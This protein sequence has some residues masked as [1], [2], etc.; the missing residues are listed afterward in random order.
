MKMPF[1]QHYDVIEA[2]P[3]YR[4]DDAFT[5]RALPG[6][7][8]CDRNF[9]DSHVFHAVLEIVAVD[10]VTIMDEKTRLFFVRKSVDDLLGRP[11]GVGIR[12]N[13]EVND[14]S[15]FV[16]EHDEDIE[17][18]KRYRGNGEKIT[19]RDV[20]YVI[21]QKRSPSLGRRFSGTDHILGHGSFGNVVAQQ[22]QFGYDSRCA[23]RRILPG[24]APNQ[25]TDF[26]FDG[27]A[28]GFPC[29]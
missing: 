27:R 4:T 2:L 11:F 8:W 17:D 7:M 24:H 29:P 15:P 20:G 3:S 14:L 12:G 5:V 25:V 23:P 26:A 10:A 13:V 22:G 9:F 19:G 18:T 28:P 1:I 6:R 16:T 21:V